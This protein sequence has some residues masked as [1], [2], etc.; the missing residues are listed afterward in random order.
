MS[1]KKQR[2]PQNYQVR[3]DKRSVQLVNMFKGELELN[4]AQTFSVAEAVNKLF[5]SCRPDLVERLN[6]IEQLEQ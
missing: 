1:G 2:P 6:K 5:E 3:L 4:T